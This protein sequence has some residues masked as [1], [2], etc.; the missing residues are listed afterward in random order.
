MLPASTPQGIQSVSRP[1]NKLMSAESTDVG[2]RK[3]GVVGLRSCKGSVNTDQIVMGYSVAVHL[4][5]HGHSDPQG[6]QATKVYR[7]PPRPSRS[8]VDDHRDL[9]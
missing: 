2:L 5:C 7:I 6:R 1:T 8:S 4:R 3:P 9:S